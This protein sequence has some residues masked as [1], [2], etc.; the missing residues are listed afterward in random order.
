GEEGERAQGRPDLPRMAGRK[1]NR[2]WIQTADTV[3][4][5]NWP[6]M[7]SEN[8]AAPVVAPPGDAGAENLSWTPAGDQ[9][10]ATARPIKVIGPPAFSLRTVFTG[11]RTLI[12]YSD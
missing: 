2:I 8:A 11:I 4:E 1:R 9:S 10:K 5:D 3:N 7:T 12:Q 6:G